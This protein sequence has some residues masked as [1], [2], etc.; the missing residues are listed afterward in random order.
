MDE[1]R[2]NRN[3]SDPPAEMWE[4]GRREAMA[5]LNKC[6]GFFLVAVQKDSDGELES[7][8]AMSTGPNIASGGLVLLAQKEVQRVL[9]LL[10]EDE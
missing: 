7:V 10:L 3:M 8:A 4:I 6:E 1:I 5:V 2:I 9:E